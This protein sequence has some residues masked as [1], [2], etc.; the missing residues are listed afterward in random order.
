MV[1]K[2]VVWDHTFRKMNQKNVINLIF[3]SDE[4]VH[5]K[6]WLGNLNAWLVN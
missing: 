1:S 6:L 5:I 2:T 3:M 4:Y